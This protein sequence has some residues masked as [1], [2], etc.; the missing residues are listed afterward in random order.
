MIRVIFMFSCV[1]V[2]ASLLFSQ[3]QLLDGETLRGHWLLAE[4]AEVA[5][6]AHDRLVSG[7]TGCS[8]TSHPV[9]L[10]STLVFWQRFLNSS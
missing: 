1:V 2:L 7:A 6:E 5:E 8:T 4:V 9:V 3:S 10:N